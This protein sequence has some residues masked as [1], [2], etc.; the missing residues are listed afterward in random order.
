MH[1]SKTQDGNNEPGSHY[2]SLGMYW[3][4]F[5]LSYIDKLLPVL[6]SCK[7]EVHPCVDVRSVVARYREIV[8]VKAAQ[9]QELRRKQKR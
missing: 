2:Y 4:V 3:F 8:N 6:V 1:T 9:G 5:R 7:V